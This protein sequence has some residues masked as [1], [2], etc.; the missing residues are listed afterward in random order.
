SWEA[1]AKAVN[2]TYAIEYKNGTAYQATSPYQTGGVDDVVKVKLYWKASTDADTDKAACNSSDISGTTLNIPTTS[3]TFGTSGGYVLIL[4]IDS[5]DAV[6]KNYAWDDTEADPT[7][8]VNFTVDSASVN[9]KAF[10]CEYTSNKPNASKA[11]WTSTS[12]LKFAYKDETTLTDLDGLSYTFNLKMGAGDKISGYTYISIDTT[13]YPTGAYKLEKWDDS[14][15]DWKPA[16]VLQDLGKYRWVV[17][18][19]IDASDTEHKF[20]SANCD[21]DGTDDHKG[22]ATLEVEMKKG[23]FDLTNVKWGYIK[24]SKEVEYTKP[25][26]YNGSAQSIQLINL[27]KGLSVN[28]YNNNKK[29]AVGYDDKKYTASV[30]ASGLVADL[31]FNKPVI[32]DNPT[33]FNKDWEIVEGKIKTDWDMKESGTGA[34][35]Y[36]PIYKDSS[37]TVVDVKYYLKADYDADPDTASEV[38]LKDIKYDPTN[39]VTYVA[40]MSIKPDE[41]GNYVLVNESGVKIDLD[42]NPNETAHMYEFTPGDGQTPVKLEISH[43]DGIDTYNGKHQLKIDIVCTDTSITIDKFTVEIYPCTNEGDL[44]ENIIGEP[45]VAWTPSSP[46]D[47][48]NVGKYVIAIGFTADVSTDNF[49]LM[50]NKFFFEIKKANV[51]GLLGGL[52]WGFIEPKKDEHGNKVTDSEGNP[53]MEE[54]PYDAQY[55]IDYELE[56]G[57]NGLTPITHTPVIIGLPTTEEKL[58]E[59]KEKGLVDP[60]MTLPQAIEILKLYGILDEDGKSA[61]TAGEGFANRGTYTTTFGL[62]SNLGKD[63]AGNDNFDPVEEMM[64]AGLVDMSGTPIPLTWEIGLKL[65][66]VPVSTTVVF[67]EEGHNLLEAL[68]LLPADLDVYYTVELKM[69]NAANMPVD[70]DGDGSVSHMTAVGK[71]QLTFALKDTTNVK[72]LDGETQKAAINPVTVTIEKLVL[73]VSGWEGTDEEAAYPFLKTQ[74]DKDADW[75]KYLDLVLTDKDGNKFDQNGWVGKFGKS[76][77]QTFTVKEAYADSVSLSGDGVKEGKLIR[78][79][80]VPFD[81]SITVGV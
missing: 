24:D 7:D 39:P 63:D 81:T 10:A 2:I 49:A 71:Y 57:E 52:G 31:R 66:N 8:R 5:T 58:N 61:I 76:F 26:E 43:I 6:S 48:V 46:N 45:L 14:A 68:G 42:V 37:V 78:E 1:G 75:T 55:T 11:A 33:I 32:A 22:F 65:I 79:F 80:K 77:T 51:S 50:S 34:I 72:W 62:P 36:L 20:E 64:P 73:S 13:R 44:A 67:C 18:L 38:A 47:P 59:L 74:Q 3:T 23:E 41:S 54:K 53:V 9:T 40:V 15:S 21:G 25:F 70:Y 28:N 17:G 60:K 29:T 12:E 69:V 27:P 4:E 16:T 30:P 56:K 19:V 35:Y